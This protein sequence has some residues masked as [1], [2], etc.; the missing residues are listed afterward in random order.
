MSPALAFLDH[1]RAPN[2]NS[3]GQD[4]HF[5][6]FYSSNSFQYQRMN[7][8]SNQGDRI[9]GFSN[10][11]SNNTPSLSSRSS[12]LSRPRF[13]KVRKQL[14][15]QNLKSTGVSESGVGSGF[16]PFRPL[17]ADPTPSGSVS[18]S[19]G[20]N[21][22]FVFGASKGDSRE[23]LGDRV[24][25]EMR[26]LK[27]GNEYIDGFGNRSLSF[28]AMKLPENMR[29]LNIGGGGEKVNLSAKDQGAFIFKTGENVNG[30]DE[31]VVETELENEL[32]EKLSVKD[33]GGINGSSVMYKTDGTKKFILETGKTGTDLFVANQ[34]PNQMKSVNLNNKNEV[35]G[36]INE[37]DDFVFGSKEGISS[38]HVGER[39]NILSNE[40]GRKLN[41]E[42]VT[43]DYS[44]NTDVGSLSSR[45]F[46]KDNQTRNLGEK[47][48]FHNLP[49]S[50]PREFSFQA[51]M[52]VND[53]QVHVDQ[54]KDEASV[55]KSASS[56]FSFSSRGVHSQPVNN[57]SEVPSMA[58]T[59]KMN[60][61]GFTSTKAGTGTPFVEFKT[62]H[63][64]TNIFSSVSQKLEFNAKRE[65]VKD[66]KGKN[67]RGKLRR[68]TPVQSW[69][70][71]DFISA[72]FASQEKP[73][74]AESYSPMDVSPY[75][76]NLAD[77]W[78]SRDNSVA[79]DESFNFD[80]HDASYDS[81]P[82]VSN[83]AVDEDLIA[84]TQC[85]D[86]NEGDVGFRETKKEHPDRVGSEGPP[87]ESVSGAETE[88]FKSANEEIDFNINSSV[89]SDETEASSNIN[90]KFE[91]QDSGGRMQFSFPSYSGD[92]GGS[93]FTF[94]ASSAVQGHISS[95]K[96]HQR[97]KNWVKLGCDSFNSSADVNV[98]HAA[99]SLQFSPLSGA[100]QLLPSQQDGNGDQ[101]PPRLKVGH[102][103]KVDRGQETKQE[104]NLTSAT[105]I[106]AQEAC[107]KWRLRGNQAYTNGHLSK[108]EDC[109]TQGINCI[110]QCETSRSGL[111]ALMLCYSNRAATYMSLGRLRDALRDCM[112]AV[113]LDPNFLRVQARAANCYLALGEVE[114]ASR[115]FRKCLQSGS[116]ICVDRKV[117]VEASDGLQKAQKVAEYMQRSA[118]FLQNKTSNS[119]ENALEV[120]DEALL[121]SS[122]SEKLLEMK[123]E[124]L[125]MLRK[126][127]EVIQLCDQT[128][129]SA[130]KNS[131]TVDADGQLTYLDGVEPSTDFTFRL[132]RSCLI[133]KSYF[134]LGKLEEAVASLEKQ[135]KQGNEEKTLESLIPLATTVHELLHNK[136]AGNEAFQAGRHAEAVEHYTAALSLT[137]ESRPFA[138]ICF[139]NRAA[140][141][142]ALGHITDAIA[143]CSLAIA[144]DGN[145]L[146][147]ISR[148]ATLYEMIRDYGRAATD[149]Q[150]LI[151]LLTNLVEMA[152]QSG[153]SD[154]SIN[155]ASDLRQARMRLAAI[156][157][158]ARKDIPLDMYLI[159]GVD[160]SVSVADIKKAYRKA[161]LRHHPDK[162]GQSLFRSD[163][164][165]DRLWKEI[166]AE[167]YKDAERL[168]KMIGEAYAVL[169]DPIKRSRYDLEEETRNAQKKRNGN[170]TSRTQ[171]DAQNY[172]FERSSS[173]RQ[174]R[175]VWRSYGASPTRRPED[176]RSNRYS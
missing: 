52:Q 139:C 135:D 118:Q 103:S 108:A 83:D 61:F 55:S 162:A 105:S 164:G 74:P 163:N 159:L 90:I 16:N 80:D 60:E 38:Y 93:D 24:A 35:N 46:V 9:S 114:H 138:A 92:V 173:R 166:G 117:A 87:E 125:F 104:P 21:N 27:I 124:A 133:F 88:S 152:S 172:P 140:A 174:W 127:E 129:D 81:P 175:D 71:H 8:S 160:P 158:E 169:S 143:D 141:Y 151:T 1:P 136:V 89:N 63:P 95:S 165:D 91:R 13:Y 119:A 155:W 115:Y 85:M 98:P 14:D 112:M 68:P 171:S 82:T 113:A 6:S 107:E 73:D 11:N 65:S 5:V 167:V 153:A 59:G 149:L 49:K 10:S 54:Q 18:G 19:S 58:R 94:A 144:L 40:M 42:S 120:I 30:L 53:D 99:S 29:K 96:G 33:S 37:K 111:R 76:E 56:S 102:N 41:I 122:Y 157:E 25:D 154:R 45:M 130:A 47:K 161:A 66:T 50:V 44:G 2:T 131:P 156:E 106:A 101:F 67:R 43:S 62:P 12:G 145:Y 69:P 31:K 57:T 28:D 126:Y 51:A 39:E 20:Y 148:R 97:K 23:N 4:S 142:K 168:F 7:P 128:M 134:N 72:E 137:V 78:C 110:S 77:L 100:S 86:I 147:A 121:I 32:K 116:D 17:S 109:Y 26:N 170:N 146:K 79:S 48:N 3:N 150:R 34:L 75:R 64:K 15:S 36:R 123:A 70:A 22:A 84:A 176:S 132:W